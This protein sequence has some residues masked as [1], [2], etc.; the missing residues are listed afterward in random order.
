MAGNNEMANPPGSAFDPL[1]SYARLSERVENQG[2]DILDMRSNMNSGFQAVNASISALASELRGNSRTPWA[3]IW[4]AIGVSFA[5][6]A[7]LGS[8]Q[9]SPIKE[10][11]NDLNTSM[12]TIVDKMVTQQE[13]QW[14]TQRGQED[15]QRTDGAIAILKDE[16]VPRKELERVWAATD[17]QIADLRDE[18]NRLRSQY[19]DTYNLRDANAELRERVDRLERN[20]LGP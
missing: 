6:M 4:T 2:K 10:D 17:R 5:I 8:Q 3:I 1:S 15:R 14:R 7:A 16:Q 18:T 9:L 19:T 13:M 20:K 12:R 11:I